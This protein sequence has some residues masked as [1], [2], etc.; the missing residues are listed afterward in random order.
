[1]SC[2]VTSFHIFEKTDVYRCLHGSA[3]FWELLPSSQS[4]SGY[5]PLDWA[6]LEGNKDVAAFILSKGVREL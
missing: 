5:T 6:I 4:I 2:F 1:M 3:F